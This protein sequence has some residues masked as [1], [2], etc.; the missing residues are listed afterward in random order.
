MAV[1]PPLDADA[2]PVG[3]IIVN[4]NGGVLV[5]DTL[6]SVRDQAYPPRRVVVVDNASSD[7]S[8]AAIAAMYP[9]VELVLLERNVGF[10]AANNV[11]IEMLADCDLVALLN[12]DAVADPLWLESL[13]AAAVDH[14]EFASFASRIE[15]ATEPGILD[16]A[17]DVYHVYGTA[18]PGRQGQTGLVGFRADGGVRSIRRSCLLSSGL[19]PSR[20][21]VRRAVLLLLRGRRSQPPPAGRR[22]SLPLRAR[23][24]CPPCRRR[25][26]VEGCLLSRSTT[27][28]ATS[29]GPTSSPC[30]RTSSGG[31]SRC[32]CFSTSARFVTL[33]SPRSRVDGATS[34]TRRC[35]R[36][37]PAMVQGSTLG[38]AAS[39][40]RSSRLRPGHE[41]GPSE[42]SSARRDPDRPQLRRTR[43]SISARVTR[44]KASD[45]P[46]EDRDRDERADDWTCER[47]E[48][49]GGER[50]RSAEANPRERSER[51][52]DTNPAPDEG[53]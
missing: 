39:G 13:V 26:S 5:L 11:A 49:A 18:W 22:R 27:R 1:E 33:R 7:G 51:G 35:H 23:R 24:P 34:E 17:G 6:A 3:V 48:N 21:F 19:A 53:R 2:P 44:P 46:G 30:L 43:A 16:S 20:R 40:V 37:L 41:Q 36:G 25:E 38:D 12:P 32:T 10:A 45:E 52:R 9:A 47:E 29:S 50:N 4:F 42:S 31:T 15:R 28:S 8:P 14:S